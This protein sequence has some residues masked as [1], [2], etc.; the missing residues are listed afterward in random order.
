LSDI[1]SR[2]CGARSKSSENVGEVL[3][4]GDVA[5][6][7]LDSIINDGGILKGWKNIV[8]QKKF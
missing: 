2:C 8:L 3:R 5:G 4:V 6:R 1:K 7:M